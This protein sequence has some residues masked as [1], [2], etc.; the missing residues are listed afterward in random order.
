VVYRCG[1]DALLLLHENHLDEKSSYMSAWRFAVATMS[2][3]AILF[4]AAKI[5]RDPG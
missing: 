2:S 5:V 3:S 4:C 1:R